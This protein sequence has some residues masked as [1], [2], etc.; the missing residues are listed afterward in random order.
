LILIDQSQNNLFLANDIFR[1]S[2]KL[3]PS[4]YRL[5]INLGKPR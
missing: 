5:V 2:Q 1:G 3:M 4:V